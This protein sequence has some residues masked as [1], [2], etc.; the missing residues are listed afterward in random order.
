MSKYEELIAK[1]ARL[2]EEYERSKAQLEKQTERVRKKEQDLKNLEGEIA[3]AVMTEHGL[4]AS[5]LADLL[6][7]LDAPQPKESPSFF[8]Q[9]G[10]D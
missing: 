3:L 4:T 7:D 1:Q 8:E 10:E 9:G 5:E 6:S 2:K